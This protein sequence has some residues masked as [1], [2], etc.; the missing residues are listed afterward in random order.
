MFFG[1]LYILFKLYKYQI[2][3]RSVRKLSDTKNGPDG[4]IEPALH[5]RTKAQIDS[6][7]EDFVTDKGHKDLIMKIEEDC[8]S[9]QSMTRTKF[10]RSHSEHIYIPIPVAIDV[11]LD[12]NALDVTSLK[13]KNK[14]DIVSLPEPLVASYQATTPVFSVWSTNMPSLYKESTMTRMT[15]PSG[16]KV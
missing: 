16:L 3:K 8:K 1:I 12:V 11:V 14:A 10:V 4:N 15:Y 2:L 7:K 13:R 9:P 6:R 5:Y